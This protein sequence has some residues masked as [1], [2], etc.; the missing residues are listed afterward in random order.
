MQDCADVLRSLK[1]TRNE[2]WLKESQHRHLSF[3]GLGI[4]LT[5][6]DPGPLRDSPGCRF[7]SS[8]PCGLGVLDLDL[9]RHTDGGQDALDVRRAG[10]ELRVFDLGQLGRRHESAAGHRSGF[11]AGCHSQRPQRGPHLCSVHALCSAHQ[12]LNGSACERAMSR[13]L[14]NWAV[15][16]AGRTSEPTNFPVSS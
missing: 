1:Q 5:L 4:L 10:R 16:F 6:V 12:S 13:Y 8:C 15:R 7:C 9:V 2:R 11:L 3:E 14:T